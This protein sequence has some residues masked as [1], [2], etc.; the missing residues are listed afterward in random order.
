LLRR[1][2]YRRL[3]IRIRVRGIRRVGVAVRIIIRISVGIP[4][5]R[6]EPVPASVVG[7]ATPAAIIPV[8]PSSVPPAAEMAPSGMPTTLGT[9]RA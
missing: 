2:I 9:E 4:P 3:G 5:P 7:A 8:I 1:A 6:A